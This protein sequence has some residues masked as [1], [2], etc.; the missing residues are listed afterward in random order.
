M[1]SIRRY[2]A[3]DSIRRYYPS[4]FPEILV[5]IICDAYNFG[6]Q[7]FLEVRFFLIIFSGMLPPNMEVAQPKNRAPIIATENSGL[8]SKPRVATADRSPELQ[9]PIEPIIAAQKFWARSE[10]RVL[11]ADR[12]TAA[13]RSEPSFDLNCYCK[14]GAQLRSQLLP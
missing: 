9:L 5:V 6:A 4:V 3:T 2:S 12:A 1:F 8:R 7:N 10:P 13:V 11:T 14:I